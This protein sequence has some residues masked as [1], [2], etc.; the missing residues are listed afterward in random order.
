MKTGYGSADKDKVGKEISDKRM[1]S[2]GDEDKYTGVIGGPGNGPR[3]SDAGG[4][5]NPSQ[6]AASKKGSYDTI[7]PYNEGGFRNAAMEHKR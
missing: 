2:P 4:K 6:G 3:V 1:P 5:S 7:A